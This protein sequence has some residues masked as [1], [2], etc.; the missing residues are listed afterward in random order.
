[1]TCC[2]ALGQAGVKKGVGGG[3]GGSHPVGDSYFMCITAASG[4]AR[5]QAGQ[6]LGNRHMEN[7][8]SSLICML[9][10]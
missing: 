2:P 5:A 8:L 7:C 1:M 6:A 10:C 3:G 4:A 9:G